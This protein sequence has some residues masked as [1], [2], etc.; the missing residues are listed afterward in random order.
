L[1]A[2]AWGEVVRR[3]TAQS[4]ALPTLEEIQIYPTVQPESEPQAEA[5]GADAVCSP[6]DAKEAV[7]DLLPI[8][9]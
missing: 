6:R 8:Q 3:F 7:V 2:E 1:Q 4:L 5:M 9:P